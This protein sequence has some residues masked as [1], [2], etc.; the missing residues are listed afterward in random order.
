[1]SKTIK[2]DES[3]YDRLTGLMGPKESY[4]QVVE[5]I[6]ILFDKVGELRDVLEGKIRF[7]EF[8]HGPEKIRDLQVR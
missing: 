8:K 4:S 6:L 7:E 1:M 5:R 3:V 2:L